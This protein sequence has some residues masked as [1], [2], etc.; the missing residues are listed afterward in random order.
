MKKKKKKSYEDKGFALVATIAIVSLLVIVALGLLSV[1]NSTSESLDS[2]DSVEEA[3]ANARMALAEAIAKLQFY[4][5]LDTRVTAP[6]DILHE[7][8]YL[9]LSITDKDNYPKQL[10]GVWRSWE[11][12]DHNRDGASRTD[13]FP[14]VS[15]YSVKVQNFDILDASVDGDATDDK[16]T[17][18]NR[19][20]GWLVSGGVY[21]NINNPPLLTEVVGTT[22]PLLDGGSVTDAVDEVH[23]IPTPIT[24]DGNETG[25]R[26]WWVQGEN[27]KIRFKPVVEANTPIDIVDQMQ[28]S[29]GPSGSAV[30]LF[31]TSNMDRVITVNS[32]ELLDE[33]TGIDMS[34]DNFHDISS[35]SMGLMVNVANGGWKR[36]FSLFAE[37]Y[38]NSINK[39]MYPYTSGSTNIPNTFSTFTLSPGV[40]HTSIQQAMASGNNGRGLIYPWSYEGT[41]PAEIGRWSMLVNFAT[42]YKNRLN[43]GSVLA[44]ANVSQFETDTDGDRKLFK[45]RSRRFPVISMVHSTL[46]LYAEENTTTGEF[47]PKLLVTPVVTMWNPYGTVI[48]MSNSGS[49]LSVELTD[50]VFPAKLI[51]TIDGTETA[52]WKMGEITSNSNTQGHYRV[53]LPMH[54]P[55][56]WQPGEVRIFSPE[57][58]LPIS[59]SKGNSITFAPGYRPGSGVYYN[60]P[61]SSSHLGTVEFGIH[62]ARVGGEFTGPNIDG[63]GFNYNYTYGADTTTSNN[64]A[65]IGILLTDDVAA[66]KALGDWLIAPT[67]SS[68]SG[69]APGP[70]APTALS[71]LATGPQPFLAAINA[72][73]FARDIL[74]DDG[75]YTYAND[76]VVNGIH[77]MRPPIGFKINTTPISKNRVTTSRMDSNQHSILMVPLSGASGQVGLPSGTANSLKGYMGGSYNAVEGLDNIVMYDV[78]DRPLRSIIELTNAPWSEASLYPP[79]TLHPLGNSTTS[80]FVNSDEIR[81]FN[82]TAAASASNLTGHDHCYSANHVML[83]DWFVSSVAEQL[84][85]WTSTVDKTWEEVYTDFFNG[86]DLPNHYYVPASSALEPSVFNADTSTHWEKIAAEIEVEGMFNI[87][88]TSVKA[89][90]MLLKGNFGVTG[91][92]PIDNGVLTLDNYDRVGSL[93]DISSSASVVAAAS[94]GTIFP[95]TTVSSAENGTN[96]SITS[97]VDP[98][99]FT[100]NHIELLAEEIVNEIKQR[101]P[102]L[103]LSE[104]F[105]RQLQTTDPDLAKAGAVESA[106]QTLASN[107]GAADNPFHDIQTEYG[108]SAST[109]Y[110]DNAT[111]LT[112]PF[113]EASTG[114]PAYGYP[115]WTRQA[116]VLRPIAGI[117]TARDD[118]FTI[119]AYGS[120]K[121]TSGAVIAEAWCEAVVQRRAEYIDSVDDKY[122]LPSDTTLTSESNKIFGRR[123]HVI[124]FRWLN[125]DEV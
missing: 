78:P 62:Q 80:P 89:W 107:S 109:M 45:S 18:E 30:N 47:V 61:T 35:S 100:D 34:K 101:G 28:I 10:T 22:T 26:A 60:L 57:D 102:F 23:V 115:G 41:K 86:V 93:S 66:K 14:S 123:Y 17:Q 87:N 95:R 5:G 88:S 75:G 58:I 67:S 55:A 105:N 92:T 43:Q 65:N 118:T 20:L 99:R 120:S 59:V 48:D 71:T 122:T 79:F 111:A 50:S 125:K 119:R 46:S 63:V 31:D 76:T 25:S 27:T 72:Y 96:S 85:D 16:D 108:D 113:P 124:Q 53:L 32:F 114:N 37:E 121:D 73:R 91:T 83:D 84:S 94:T 15:D 4:T 38:S 90:T 7:N 24:V 97:L 116:D 44:N 21:D 9:S 33:G 98:I 12:W 70:Q 56:T 36:D 81:I 2:S 8:P 49:V 42:D 117:L 68:S 103:S 104:F 29:P 64:S 6:A 51:F 77:N 69:L 3:R 13:R 82:G 74:P 106:L 19:F 110:P 52:E 1:S 112:Y 11:G 54:S 40:E 39:A